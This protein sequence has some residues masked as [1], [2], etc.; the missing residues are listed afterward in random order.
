MYV[1]FEQMP[2]EA[3]VWIYQAGRPFSAEEEAQA[4][5]LLQRFV[6][7]WTAHEQ[8]LK[9][10]YLLAHQQFVVLTVDESAHQAS[11]C[12]IDKSVAI[13][14]QLEAQFGM[15]LLDRTK[16]MFLQPDG[17]KLQVSMSEIRQLITSG[18]IDSETLTF[19]N[20]VE[21][22]A[23]FRQVWQVPA[24]QSWLARYF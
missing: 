19:N 3:R 18:M 9:A 4:S 23:Q 21:N 22:L 12:S 17:T 7:Q 11:G 13:I 8:Q 10:S 16:V 24:K 6:T 1:P 20:L 15:P 2:D 14:R 5:L